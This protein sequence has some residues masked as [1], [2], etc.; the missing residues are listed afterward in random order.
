MSYIRTPEERFEGLLD[1]PFAPNYLDINFAGLLSLRMHYVDEGPKDGPVALMLHGEPTWSYLYRKMIPLFASRG[2][3]VVVPDHVGFGRSDKPL[4]KTMY[5]FKAHID[6]LHHLVEE[7]SLENITLICQ[8]WGGPIGLGVLA[9]E[10]ERFS[11][12]VAAN[13]MLHTV[14]ANLENRI[15]WSNHSVGESDVRI[16]QGLLAWILYSQRAP[17]FE[18]SPSVA[19]TTVREMSSEVLAAYDA[20]FPDERYKA[21]MRQFPALI[22]VTRGDEGALINQLTWAALA[23]FRKPFLTLFSDSDPATKGWEE[24]FKARVPGAAGQ[25][26][27][28]IERAGHFVQEDAGEELA[29]RILTWLGKA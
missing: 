19:G 18:A 5:S 10:Q 23:D 17:D 4:E 7:L 27:A 26:H 13:T 15:E 11:S 14:E 6:A 3:R 8:D 28:Q 24:L 22:P 1:Y 12:V 9:R 2:F 20:P 21:G 16:S 25:P 29:I